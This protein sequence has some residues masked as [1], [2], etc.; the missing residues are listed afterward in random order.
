MILIYYLYIVI[1]CNLIKSLIYIKYIKI[2][3][4]FFLIW[5]SENKKKKKK[6]KKI[7][8]KKKKNNKKI[9]KN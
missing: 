7:K 1:Y 4:Y 2:K 8:K 5:I 6:K 3:L 9:N